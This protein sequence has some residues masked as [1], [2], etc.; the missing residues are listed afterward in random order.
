MSS[1]ALRQAKTC[2]ESSGKRLRKGDTEQTDEALTL[3]WAATEHLRRALQPAADVRPG[4][5]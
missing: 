2:L 4:A 1:D 3:L 5:E